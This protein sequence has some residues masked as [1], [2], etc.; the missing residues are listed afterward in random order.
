MNWIVNC[1]SAR[2]AGDP[3]QI[4]TD[5]ERKLAESV[6]QKAAA[7]E[8]LQIINGSG[9]DLT[10]ERK[11]S[12]FIFIRSGESCPFSCPRRVM[13]AAENVSI[14]YQVMGDDPIDLIMVPGLLSHVEFFHKLQG[15]TDFLH[16]LTGFARVISFD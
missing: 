14:A 16:R 7:T 3:E 11:L 10:L 6:A 9:G 2:Y 4:I 1:D 12:T 13:R 15:Y 5:L 8:V